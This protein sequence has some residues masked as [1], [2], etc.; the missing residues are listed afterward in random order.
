VPET[1]DEAVVLDVASSAI[2]A[3]PIA[4]TIT[5]AT[6]IDI[7]FFTNQFLLSSRFITTVRMI[8]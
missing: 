2:T 8:R 6:T 1:L 5:S 4:H 3:K 7:S